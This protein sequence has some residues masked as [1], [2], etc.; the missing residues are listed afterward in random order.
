MLSNVARHAKASA[1]SIR[2]YVDAPPD[3]VLH[4]MVRD[5]GIGA[6]DAALTHPQS[7]GVL[8]MRERAGHFGGSVTIAS[9]PGRGTAV[10]LAMPLPKEAS[11]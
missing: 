6:E 10:H 2:L 7:Y 8:G 11:R 5:D 3:P 9:A 4:V 1:V